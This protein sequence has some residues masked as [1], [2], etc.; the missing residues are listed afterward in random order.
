MSA[1]HGLE[2]IL[3]L[4]PLQEGLLFHADLSDTGGAPGAPDGLDV[5]TMR[6]VFRLDGELDATSLRR[7]AD[8]V[9]DRHPHLRAAFLQEGLDRPVQAIP[10]TADVPW[11]E[12]DLR[13]ATPDRRKAEEQR[14]LDEERGHRFDPTRPPLLR[15]T[16]I[17]HGDRDHTLILTAHHILLDGWSVPLLGKEL[18][19]AYA[20]HT[21]APAAPALPPVRPYRDFLAWLAA[22]DRPAA[23]AA[24]H[25][26]LAPLSEPTLLAPAAAGAAV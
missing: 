8:T 14:V 4:A 6:L 18:F 21:K 5:Y 23:E 11:R 24:W 2:D 10:R 19:T 9:L 3:P 25:E 17:R 26:A 1:D 20:Q 15:L 12:I 22:Q 7:A 13:D 16:L